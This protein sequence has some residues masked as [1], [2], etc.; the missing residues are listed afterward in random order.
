MT[1]RALLIG[2]HA[3]RGYARA[4]S[5][6]ECDPAVFQPRAREFGSERGL[7]PAEKYGFELTGAR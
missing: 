5:D 1:T 2:V 3:G 4:G 6:Q 7:M